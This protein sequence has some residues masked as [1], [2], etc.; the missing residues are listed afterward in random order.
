MANINDAPWW[1]RILEKQGFAILFGIW[2]MW[3]GMDLAAAHKQYLLDTTDGL[4]SLGV[5]AQRTDEKHN[6]FDLQLA[7]LRVDQ[8]RTSQAI[9]DVLR[10]LSKNEQ[11]SSAANTDG[12]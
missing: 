4:K 8:Q 10:E 9:I 6:R 11:A 3:V 7:E 2:A 1:Q 5:F 12:A